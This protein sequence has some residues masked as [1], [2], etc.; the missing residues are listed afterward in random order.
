MH[1]VRDSRAAETPFVAEV[2]EVAQARS[3][4]PPE[5]DLQVHQVISECALDVRAVAGCG[6]HI[7]SI[8]TLETLK[9]A[10]IHRSRVRRAPRLSGVINFTT[11]GTD[12]I[13]LSVR[14]QA[15][16]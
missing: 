11:W 1:D 9:D 8:E 14:R 15:I 16:R 6:S 12:N 2:V 7:S 4:A 13:E 5:H 10:A 3:H